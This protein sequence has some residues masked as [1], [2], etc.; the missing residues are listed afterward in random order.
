MK[1]QTLWELRHN[2]AAQITAFCLSILALYYGYRKL[3]SMWRWY[4]YE[5]RDHDVLVVLRGRSYGK[6]GGRGFQ[7]EEIAQLM[8]R[9][10]SSVSRS[11]RRLERNEKAV[12]MDKGWYS[13]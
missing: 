3:R 12:Q 5:L 13:V 9:S 6:I 1:W 4:C 10:R 8:N 2:L 7:A 11:L